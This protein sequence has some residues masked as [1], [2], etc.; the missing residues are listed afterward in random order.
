[1]N[2]V[3]HIEKLLQE[4]KRESDPITRNEKKQLLGQCD[5]NN[6]YRACRNLGVTPFEE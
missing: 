3:E 4:V 6:Y 5:I 1:M 2:N